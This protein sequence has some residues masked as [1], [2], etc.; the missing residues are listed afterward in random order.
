MSPSVDSLCSFTTLR[1]RFN[2]NGNLTTYTR[3]R[4]TRNANARICKLANLKALKCCAIASGQLKCTKPRWLWR[5]TVKQN[6]ELILKKIIRHKIAMKC[7]LKIK[8]CKWNKQWYQRVVILALSQE[9]EKLQA[10]VSTLRPY[11]YI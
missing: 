10:N 11:I 3:I 5:A 1:R 2:W 4:Y 6:R 8:I 7:L 9:I